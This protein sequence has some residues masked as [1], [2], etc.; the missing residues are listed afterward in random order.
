MQSR[1]RA[2]NAMNIRNRK[3]TINAVNPAPPKNLCQPPDASCQEN[4]KGKEM[5]MIASE[6][7]IYQPM[8]GTFLPRTDTDR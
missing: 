6:G 5:A 8:L 4:N 2:G 7:P 1:E 3:K